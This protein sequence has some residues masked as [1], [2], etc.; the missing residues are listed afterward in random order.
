MAASDTRPRSDTHI[1]TCSAASSSAL[2]F[3]SSAMESFGRLLRPCRE[4]PCAST[5]MV[6]RHQ[7]TYEQGVQDVLV[8]RASLVGPNS[9][10][11]D[12]K[13]PER[14]RGLHTAQV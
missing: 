11:P 6:R 3:A 10:C 8:G 5:P 4:P 14:S 1:S 12:P 13:L 7:T 2:S 9:T